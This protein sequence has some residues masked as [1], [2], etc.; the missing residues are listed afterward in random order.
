M[1]NWAIHFARYSVL[2][3]ILA[4][5]V[6]PR[7]AQPGQDLASQDEPTARQQ[8]IESLLKTLHDRELQETDPDQV[9]KAIVQL[10]DMRAVEAIDDLI[11]LLTYRRVWLWE[12]KREPGQPPPPRDGFGPT[13]NTTAAYPATAALTL[14]G[15]SALPALLKVIETHEVDSL[16]AKNSRDT[17]RAILRHERS[18]ADQLFRE[19]AAK[20]SSPEIAKRF[21]HALE[22]ADADW[23]AF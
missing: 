19:A 2:P 15:K 3:L 18:G 5:A 21:L 20:A 10:R 4:A 23:E 9:V 7:P 22:T 8:K 6:A 13:G 17:V 14:I 16:E 12:K 1:K 11:G